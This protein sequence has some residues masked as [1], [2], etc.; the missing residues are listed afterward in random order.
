MTRDRIVIVTPAGRKRYM[1]ILVKY[2]LRDYDRGLFDEWHVWKNTVDPVD[3]AYIDSL[4]SLP[5]VKVI[6]LDCPFNKAFTIHT[7]WKHCNEPNTYYLRLDDDIVYIHDNYIEELYNMKKTHPEILAV[8]PNIINNSIPMHLSQCM[9]MFDLK[10]P[11][12]YDCFNHNGT[13]NHMATIGV[14]RKFLDE[15]DKS[16]F[17]RDITWLMYQRERISICSFMIKGSDLMLTKVP[18]D[19]E[20]FISVVMCKVHDRNHLIDYRTC[21]VHY[22]FHTQRELL[23]L[24]AP[25]ILDEYAQ[26]ATKITG[27]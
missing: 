18:V 1:E 24:A 14:H 20:D 27:K 4:S 15:P 21:C 19:E 11:V 13:R 9:G 6:N 8:F 12:G 17:T 16:K 7:F 5:F 25:G 22:A 23:E 10:H 26:L 2:L 3:A